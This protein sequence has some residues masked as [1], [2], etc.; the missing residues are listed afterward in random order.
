MPRQSHMSESITPAF[1]VLFGTICVYMILIV[2][3]ILINFKLVRYFKLTSENMTTPNNLVHAKREL[4]MVRRMVILIIVLLA[5]CFPYTLV[6]FMSF[7]DQAPKDH[8]RIA[9]IFVNASVLSVMSSWFQFTDLL[10][11]IYAKR[12]YTP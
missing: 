12:I 8:F 6:T 1:Y 5:I 7:F 11:N 2:V 3:I 9:Y 10:K 4:I